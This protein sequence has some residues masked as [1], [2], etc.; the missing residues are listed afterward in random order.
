M[1]GKS[2]MG[3]RFHGTRWNTLAAWDP[4]TVR[5][6]KKLGKHC[7]SFCLGCKNVARYAVFFSCFARTVLFSLP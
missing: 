7:C 3:M 1:H 4:Q 5:H 2:R 6:Q